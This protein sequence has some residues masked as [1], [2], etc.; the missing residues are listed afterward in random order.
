[1]RRLEVSAPSH[2]KKIMMST[3]KQRLKF[4]PNISAEHPSLYWCFRD[5]QL[6]GVDCM[7]EHVITPTCEAET[8]QGAAHMASLVCRLGQGGRNL[9]KHAMLL[10]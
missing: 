6:C 1:M 10:F 2:P 5:E 7:H 9:A 8:A 4:Y 3:W